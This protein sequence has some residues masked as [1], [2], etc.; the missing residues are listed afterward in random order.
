M[1]TR[2]SLPLAAL[3]GAV[4]G[5]AISGLYAQAKPPAYYISSSEVI[6]ADAFKDY[7]PK[8]QATLKTF[9]GRVVVR[10]GKI[11]PFVGDAPK[12]VA[13]VAFDSLEQAQPWRTSPAYTELQPMRGAM[14]FA[15]MPRC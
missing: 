14:R 12:R 4:F 5:A 13:I 6:D 8:V 15:R 11:V 1:T 10:G 3:G 2:W 9:N 7:V